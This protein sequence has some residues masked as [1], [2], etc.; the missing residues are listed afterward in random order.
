MTLLLVYVSLAL[1]FSFVCSVL[2]AVLLS[3]TPAY[4]ASLEERGRS[5]G[6]TWRRLKEDVD[7]PLGAILSLNTIAHTVGAAGAGAQAQEI[8]GSEVLAITSVIL[9]LLILYLSEIIPKTL[10]A[11]YWRQLA[12]TVARI[13]PPLIWMLYPLVWIAELLARLFS[14]GKVSEA[15]SPGEI[16]ALARLAEEAGT[17]RGAEQRIVRNLFQLDSVAT[18]DVMTPRTVMFSLDEEATI[19][20]VLETHPEL[21]FSRIPIWRGG[22]DNVVGYVLKDDLLLA[23]TRG[24]GTKRLA[25]LEREIPV[26]VESLPLSRLFER[27]VEE[28]EHFALVIDGFGSVAGVVTM[29]DVLET[30]LGLEIVDEADAVTDM[31]ALARARWRERAAR[32]GLEPDDYGRKPAGE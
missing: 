19:D 14:R 10:G 4:V 26:V 23:A 29:E 13:L 32:L 11:V 24:G 1:G 12:P 2:E 20:E 9:T 18:R 27:L 5:S 21:H 8:W 3:A 17:V 16:T 25:E 31:R 28:R 7:R 6:A 22:V 15:I 30:L